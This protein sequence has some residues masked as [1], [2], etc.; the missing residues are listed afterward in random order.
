VLQ[1][2]S[3]SENPS[4]I[5]ERLINSLERPG[6]IVTLNDIQSLEVV[7]KKGKR[8][9]AEEFES[10]IE[11]NDV[12]G[13]SPRKG[14]FE[15]F[16]ETFNS[17]Y[18]KGVKVFKERRHLFDS[19][20][21]EQILGYSGKNDVKVIGLVESIRKSKKGNTVIILEDP[22]GTI[23]VVILKSDR[24]LADLSR[25][26]VQDDMICVEGVTGSRE[27]GIIIA[28]SIS[29]P[30]VPLTKPDRRGD[31]PLAIAMISDI[32]VGSFEFMEKEFLRFLK[33]LNS[34]IGNQKQRELSQRV[35]YL[36]VAGDLVDG[37]G[38]YPGQINDL[39]I[40]DI[41]DQYKKLSEFFE[42][43][44]DYIEIIISP[45]NHDATRQAEP[46][47][48][49]FEDFAEKLYS[50]SN[51]HMVGN[52]CYASLHGTSLLIYHGRSMDD[53]ISKIP[54]NS[55]QR[56]E[57]AMLNL[58]K[59]RQL[60]PIFGEK[61]PVTPGGVDSL[62]IDEV[63]DILHCGHVHTTGVLNYRGV[64]LIN[65][66]AFQSQTEFQ[67]KLNMHPDPGKVPVFDIAS[68]NTTIMKFT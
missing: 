61:V 67:K 11:I 24:D 36:V 7:V 66:G 32:H 63:P 50:M 47:S 46:Q 64:T 37:V 45:G 8:R 22:T 49:I 52:P 51:I 2:I 20:N 54:G 59:K 16:V 3:E 23:P 34:E 44:P 10:E 41:Y 38:I 65:S 53:I 58:L 27:G 15:G 1:E 62:F 17:R 57:K 12:S 5:V 60:V 31:E 4:E 39:E 55:Y 26:V 18:E 21:V 28:R 6:S 29:F 33:W 14:S 42:F 35:K 30:D 43:V 9:L 48:P 56:P 19:L 40:K 68:G 25:S 13:N